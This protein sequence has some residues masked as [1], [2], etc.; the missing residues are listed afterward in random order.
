MSNRSK[1]GTTQ[2]LRLIHQ[3]GQH[4]QQGKHHGEI[5]LAMTIVVFKVVPLVFQGVQRGSLA[6]PSTACG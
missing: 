6:T 3:K 4:H 1:Q 5:L 2:L